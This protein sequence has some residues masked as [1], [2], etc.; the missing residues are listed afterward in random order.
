MKVV[1]LG[2]SITYGFPY[3]PETSWV[4]RLSENVNV[5]FINKGI[6]GNTTS[7]MLNRFERA[8]ISN[9]PT[10][11]VLMGGINDVVCGESL[12]RV[13]YNLKTMTERALQEDIKVIIGMPTAVDVK[14]W[15][16]VLKKLRIW[17]EEYA[18]EN[19]LPVIHFEQAF[20]DENG[21]VRSELLLADG[22]HPTERGYQ[23][24]YKQIDINIFK[25]QPE[26]HPGLKERPE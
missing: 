22:G 19:D 24:M 9:K 23:E 10:H 13:K 8:V 2:D 5:Q 3:G 14:S 1:C 21:L 25:A 11:L 6:N 4:A 20:Y 16:N 17:I 7:D 18:R 26:Y 12:D 15:E